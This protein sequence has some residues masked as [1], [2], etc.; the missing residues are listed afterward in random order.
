MPGTKVA[1]SDAE[2][3]IA[4]YGD[5]FDRIGSDS[6][7]YLGVP[8]GTPFPQRALP[9]DSLGKE[10]HRYEFTGQLPDDVLIEVSEVAR[11]LGRPGGGVQVRFLRTLPD[12]STEPISVSEPSPERMGVLR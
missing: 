10:L 6:G 4:T 7:K 9:P 1:F 11:G 3:F 2:E 8:P 12:R 5:R